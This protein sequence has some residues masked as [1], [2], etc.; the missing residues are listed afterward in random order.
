LISATPGGRRKQV[1]LRQ[2]FTPV[3]RARIEQVSSKESRSRLILA[4]PR[5]ND[6]KDN[7]RIYFGNGAYRFRRKRDLV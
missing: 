7:S 2:F 1:T 5:G 6:G 4:K 3:Q